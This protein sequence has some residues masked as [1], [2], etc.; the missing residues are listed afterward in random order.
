MYEKSF[1]EPIRN[2]LDVIGWDDE[3]KATL[4]EFFG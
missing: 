3:P 1:V 2:I 4:E